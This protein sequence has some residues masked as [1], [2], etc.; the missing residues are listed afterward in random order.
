MR[1]WDLC[2]HQLYTTYTLVSIH[3]FVFLFQRCN[4]QTQFQNGEYSKYFVHLTAKHYGYG[5]MR[6]GDEVSDY[7]THF[8]IIIL[9]MT[10]SVESTQCLL[11]CSLSSN[12]YR[13]ERFDPI[14]I[15]IIFFFFFFFLIARM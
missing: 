9:T 13:Y 8:K 7:S 12:V 6:G 3:C 4:A 10:Y 11:V 2:I 14:F 5:E 1:T 15:I